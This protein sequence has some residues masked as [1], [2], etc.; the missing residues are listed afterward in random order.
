MRPFWTTPRCH[1]L[2]AEI[3]GT[4]ENFPKDCALQGQ[5]AKGTNDA[6]SP[7]RFWRLL[8]YHF[9]TGTFWHDVVFGLKSESLNQKQICWVLDVGK[10]ISL[11]PTSL[12]SSFIDL[13]HLQT[14]TLL[15]YGCYYSLDLPKSPY[16]DQLL[17]KHVNVPQQ[18]QSQA[19]SP[20][21]HSLVLFPNPVLFLLCPHS[22]VVFGIKWTYISFFSPR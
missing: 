9:K 8:N 6:S 2:G 15:P 17:V 11:L 14:L 1:L 12:F 16:W 5:K 10:A 3:Q 7:W 13:L 18:R 19:L 21:Q 22:M 4:K 20:G